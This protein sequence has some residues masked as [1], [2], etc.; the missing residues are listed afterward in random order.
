MHLAS[1]ADHRMSANLRSPMDV[2]PI[3]DV[4]SVCDDAASVEP[5]TIAY[6]RSLF[7]TCTSVHLSASPN[8]GSWSHKAASM[9]LRS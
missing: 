8:P 6:N 1:G 5:N 4:G 9:E 2:R 7:D 3:A